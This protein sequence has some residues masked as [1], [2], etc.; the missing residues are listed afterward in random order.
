[1]NTSAFEEA[2]QKLN[3]EQKKA[4][5]A[6]EGPVMVIAGPGTGKTTIL[7]LRIAKI[8]KETDAQPENIL[9]L[10][11]TN[12]GVHAMRKR[13]ITYIGDDA[14]RVPIFTFH[15]FAEHIIKEFPLYF[16]DLEHAEVITDIARIKI[17]ESIIETG[18][19]THLTSLHDPFR[20]L[21]EVGKGI[22]EIKREGLTPDA[23]FALIPLWEAE[24]MQDESI[25]YKRNYGEFKAGDI[26]PAEKEKVE[27]RVAKARE[28]GEVYRAY[29]EALQQQGLYDFH[30]MIL[31]VLKELERNKNLKLDLGEQ[32]QYLLVDE[33]QDTNEGQNSL[34]ELLTD[35]EH[36]EGRPNLFTVGDEKQSIY[37]FQGASAETFQ[38]FTSHFRDVEVITLKENYRSTKDILGAAHSLI[39]HTI[40]DTTPLSPQSKENVPVTVLEFSNYKFELLSIAKDI[41]KKLDAGVPPHEIAIIYRS[42][43]HIREIKDVFESTGI[44]YTV[45]SKD[46]VFS[47]RDIE[48]LISLLRVIQNPKD[49]HH[50]AEALF[51]DFLELD[52]YETV[53]MLG[54]FRNER[55]RKKVSLFRILEKEKRY[56]PFLTMIKKLKTREANTSFETFFKEF[57]E[58]TGYLTAMLKNA[59]SQARLLKLDAL[60]NEI[61]RQVSTNT[62]YRLSDCLSFVDA[63]KK[64]GLDLESGGDILPQG[65]VCMTAHRS[66]G[67]EYQHVYMVNTTRSNWEKSNGGPSIALPIEDYKGTIDDER[68]LFYVAMTRAKETLTIS[69][70]QFDFEGKEREKSQFITE[71]DDA[72]IEARSTEIFEKEHLDSLSLFLRTAHSASSVFDVSYLKTLFLERNLSVTALNNYMQCPVQYLFRNLLQLPSEYTHA[73]AYG[74]AVH[75][76]LEA[77]FET[78]KAKKKIQTKSLLLKVFKEKM[79]RAPLYGRD[80]ERYLKKGTE[81]LA[82]YHDHYRGVWSATIANELHIKRDF[83]L[84]D[85]AAV[86]LSGI[87]DKIEYLDS[88]GEGRIIIVDYKT[89][90]P[91]SEKSTREQKEALHRQIVFYHLLLEEYKGGKF[92]VEKAALDFIEQ[93]KKG[94]YEQHSFDVGENDIE[95]LKALITE[96]AAEVMNGTFLEKG[97]G[98]RDCEYC[99]LY[100]SIGR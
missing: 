75:R 55:K 43:R 68:R 46:N 14:Y 82:A 11:F 23:F 94:I 85:D 7:T 86:T 31:R 17:L 45:L 26:K 62:S 63:Y 1:M 29:Q 13:L 18:D 44:P 81:D 71:L 99:A 77:F 70:S 66:K 25:F 37:R 76:T 83:K 79:L 51:I 91:Y 21:R 35:A 92:T 72:T 100:Q 89:G 32:Y 6:I 95:S 8:L 97:C 88:E 54:V 19:F 65:V 16:T 10:T 20:S 22:N 15:S 12:S 96:M 39:V 50:L 28:V 52:P 42:N 36:L 48:Q 58:E 27:R 93:N 59:D 87:L 38:H 57:L 84:S 5:N 33:H 90:K 98:K 67:L 64:Y 30:D 56:A 53:E 69:S 74:D 49:D 60:M 9:A 34:I 2:Y 61:K 78:S 24:L 4:V 80:Y 41:Q 73:L 3:K 40:P 47:R